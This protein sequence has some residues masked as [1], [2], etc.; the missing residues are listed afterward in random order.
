MR[1]R[2][3]TDILALIVRH[4]ARRRDG[5]ATPRLLRLLVAHGRLHGSQAVWLGSGISRPMI[6]VMAAESYAA[7]WGWELGERMASETAAAVPVAVARR[8]TAAFRRGADAVA[9]EALD[10]ALGDASP[11]LPEGLACNAEWLTAETGADGRAL[12]RAVRL[13]TPDAARWHVA[14]TATAES[15]TWE[16]YS[17]FLPA[18]V[19]LRARDGSAR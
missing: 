11:C 10:D 13:A 7:A 8:A 9:Y 1:Q 15:A 16:A 12:A 17:D 2:T 18:G 6:A 4:G 5:G 3:V 19:A 14:L